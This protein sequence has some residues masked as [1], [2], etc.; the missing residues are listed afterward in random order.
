MQHPNISSRTQFS[1]PS[2]RKET[3]PWRGLKSMGNY[4]KPLLGHADLIVGFPSC[5]RTL[6]ERP[7]SANV[8]FR[9]AMEGSPGTVFSWQC[10][11]PARAP[12]ASWASWCPPLGPQAPDSESNCKKTIGFIAFRDLP[13]GTG[14]AGMFFLV[15][16]GVS[17][18]APQGR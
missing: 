13:V 5:A 9:C 15:R 10:F 2:G 14:R 6:L 1:R 18:S 17:F 4:W 12:V 16:R 3:R 8:F 11:L 7:E